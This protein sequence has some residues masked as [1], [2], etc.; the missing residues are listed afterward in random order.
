MDNNYPKIL[1]RAN[2]Q[3]ESTVQGKRFDTTTVESIDA[4]D[5][6]IAEGF[7]SQPWEATRAAE[8]AK[9]KADAAAEA[10]K[11]KAKAEGEGA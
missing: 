4:E 9:A 6:A 7:C 2:E 3:G 8:K 11:R 10:P 1:Y 5:A